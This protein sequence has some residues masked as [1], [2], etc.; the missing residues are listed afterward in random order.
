M[1]ALMLNPHYKGLRFIQHVDKEKAQQIASE[2]DHQVLFPF[3][4]CAYNFFNPN[5]AGAQ[6]LN[7]IPQR[8][9]P[10]VCMTSWK[11]KINDIVNGERTIESFPYQK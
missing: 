5:D 2:Y 7:F 10:Q 9:K 3:L 1:L 6:A 8:L 11:L 4:V